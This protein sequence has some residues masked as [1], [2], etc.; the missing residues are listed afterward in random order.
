MKFY[1]YKKGL[2]HPERGRGHTNI[3]GSL[4]TVTVARSFSH[5]EGRGGGAKKTSHSLKGGMQNV[6]PFLAVCVCEGGGGL[7]NVSDL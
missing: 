5:I 1:P 4:Y 2:S 3:W 6:L 7:Q